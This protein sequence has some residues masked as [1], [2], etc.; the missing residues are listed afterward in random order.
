MRGRFLQ[1]LIA[2]AV[3][4]T[5]SAALGAAEPETVMITFH[6][7]AGAEQAVADV[8]ARQVGD[9]RLTAVGYASG[10]RYFPSN[11]C[12]PPAPALRGL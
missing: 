11:T 7:K 8:I 9:P 3:V 4:V 5:A 2:A 6:P 1:S 12:G 10:A